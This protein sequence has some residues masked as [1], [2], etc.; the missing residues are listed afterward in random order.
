[1]G[2]LLLP[3]HDTTWASW[4]I[5]VVVVYYMVLWV[6][7]MLPGRPAPREVYRP[8]MVILV[9]AR[10]EELVIG[11]TVERLISLEYPDRLVVVLND[12]STD[13]T[14]AI[15]HAIAEARSDVEIIDRS[16]DIAGQ[17]KS[18]VLNHG[19]RIVEDML[20]IHD[21]RLEGRD[22]TDI[23][24]GIVDA[25]GHLSADAL[26]VVGPYFADDTVG[27]LQLGVKIY[28]A[29]EN[30]LAR[31][32]DMEFV[33]FSSLVQV[34][35]DR[36]GSSGLGGNGQF[37]RLSALRSL[38]RDPWNPMALTE[39]LELG[40]ELV[41]AG[42]TT[43]FT[44]RA[45]VYQQGLT[46]WRP[47]LRQRTRWIQGHYQCWRQIPALAGARRVRLAARVDLIAY[48]LL[49]V[50]VVVVSFSVATGILT[51]FG[52]IDSGSNFLG[53]VHPLFVRQLGLAFFTL[54]PIVAFTVTY[55]R[56]SDYPLRWWEV[57]AFGF[58]FT[59]YSYVWVTVTVRA[60]FRILRRRRGWVKT[61]R[62]ATRQGA[63]A[64]KCG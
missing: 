32:Q 23:V 14:G 31:M 42:W 13:G 44:N 9:P 3:L 19:F 30:M 53:G 39:D 20:A 43:R 51:T 28:N 49:V 56:H 10:N 17:G 29:R 27:Q 41:R 59:L 38:G 26:Q 37:T 8:F 57:L 60:W 16:P 50:T 63:A 12:G 18:A 1:V 62:V 25:D 48:L 34:A 24:V 45:Y 52:V 47:L 54:G 21:P 15:A 61:P 5:A 22:A 40:L 2:F 58:L 4:F 55:Q 7:S 36:I 11:E 46:S 35:R 33:G 6:V 64:A